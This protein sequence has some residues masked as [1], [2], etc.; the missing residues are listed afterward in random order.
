MA[1]AK[2]RSNARKRVENKPQRDSS[3]DDE[4]RQ[5]KILPLIEKLSSP[6]AAERIVGLGAITAMADDSHLRFLL[7]KEKIVPLVMT[8]LLKD[9]SEEVVAEAYGLLRNLAVEEGYDV[10]VYMFRQN[11]LDYVKDI[12][13]VI[14]NNYGKLADKA[15]MLECL[16][17]VF[18][19]LAALMSVDDQIF[20]KIQASFTQLPSF[21]VKVIELCVANPKV[22]AGNLLE[23]TLELCFA[24]SESNS[25]FFVATDDFDFSNLV[26]QKNPSVRV[27]A[28]GVLY[29]KFV[30]SK[31]HK[32]IKCNDDVLE[33]I[34]NVFMNVFSSVDIKS[35]EAQVNCEIP[36]GT[37]IPKANEI[38]KKALT[39]RSQIN[40]VQIAL[41][42]TAA[43][44][45][46]IEVDPAKA[47][48]LLASDDHE[49]EE[50]E[51]EE[52][53]DD[54][55]EM[56]DDV[57]IENS[58]QFENDIDFGRDDSS[59][60]GKSA[61]LEL[62]LGSLLPAV[63]GERIYS[64]C[65]SRSLAA[66]NNILWTLSTH[67]KLDNATYKKSLE[68]LWKEL[69]PELSQNST[70]IEAL[71]SILGCLWNIAK[72]FD[73]AVPLE[74]VINSIT[75]K[76]YDPVSYLVTEQYRQTRAVFPQ[77][78]WVN[79]SAKAIGF[80]SVVAMGQKNLEVTKVI[81]EFLV[82]LLQSVSEL[83]P[84][85][86]SDALNAIFDIY[87]DKEYFYD[88]E[89]FVRG[90]LLDFLVQILPAVRK[91]T[92]K[93]NKKTQ[94]QLREV[95]DQATINLARFIDYKRKERV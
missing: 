42:L 52:V 89:L 8:K 11:I 10:A 87:G 51:E 73:G 91:V 13:V 36:A 86:M 57:Y 24:L 58:L 85:T 60:E 18:G 1:K 25:S 32:A 40:A 30:E 62:M 77:D 68:N 12:L 46:T 65:T 90:K 21:L 61:V 69:V 38:T 5:K 34:L 66:L 59:G 71:A 78:E 88:E 2:R 35:A 53:E 94:G 81:T 9:S 92:K 54:D 37:P 43:V 70:D 4:I 15:Q 56:D 3:H 27:Y 19:L 39:S 82:K 84:A 45:E 72:T 64:S 47:H 7:Q 22:L 26:H 79:Y 31:I 17:N 75:G 95:C 20:D 83:P 41:E 63:A 67:L 48:G 49:M 55:D 44:S 14:E 74:P 33:S 29:N 6:E 93:V 80:L 23:T 50:E 28:C 76:T 16:E